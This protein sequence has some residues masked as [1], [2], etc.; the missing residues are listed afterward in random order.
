MKSHHVAASR[1][2]ARQRKLQHEV[3]A[4]DVIELLY[5]RQLYII[6]RDRMGQGGWPPRNL[7][8]VGGWIVTR[9]LAETF[10]KSVGEVAADIINLDLNGLVLDA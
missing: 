9:L 6:I 3:R 4:A 2:A 1:K 7:A 5:K 10:R 8:A